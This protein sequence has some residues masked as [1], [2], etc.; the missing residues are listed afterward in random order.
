ML[1]PGFGPYP[2]FRCVGMKLQKRIEKILRLQEL[3]KVYVEN[4]DLQF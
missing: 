1:N 4:R 3:F 2:W